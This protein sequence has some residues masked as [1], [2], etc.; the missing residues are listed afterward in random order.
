ML[1]NPN[2]TCVQLNNEFHLLPCGQALAYP[3]NSLKLNATAVAIW[4]YLSKPMSEDALVTQLACDYEIVTADLAEFSKEIHTFLEQLFSMQAI[5][6]EVTQTPSGVAADCH[7]SFLSNQETFLSEQDVSS[8][9]DFA[10]SSTPENVDA[11]IHAFTFCIAD[12]GLKLLTD[13]PADAVFPSEFTPFSSE[14]TRELAQ[15]IHIVAEKGPDDS[16]YATLISH[17]LL[18]VYE[19]SNGYLLRYPESSSMRSVWMS[20]DGSEVIIYV[21]P[22]YDA[23]LRSDIFHAIRVTFLYLAEKH[24]LYAI[25]S[26]SIEYRGKAWLFSGPSG[27]GKS[28]HT[29][30]WHDALSVERLNGDIN[31]IG[32]GEA[33]VPTVY[34][35]PWCGTS[36]IFTTNR[37][38]LGG[39][40]LL[41]QASNNQVLALSSSEQILGIVKRCIS[42]L[43]TRSQ[44]Q[45]CVALMEELLPS[46][47]VFHLHCTISQE[48]VNVIKDAIDSTF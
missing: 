24:D 44:M 5:T 41:S 43:W 16:A 22:P 25:H 29:N 27:T 15:T 9:T 48:A 4:N 23:T 12:L 46:I 7:A 39:I 18:C 10:C 40:T 20:R 3:H 38:P 13:L 21:K 31:L 35:I 6:E 32:K 2:F 36:E 34:G 17:P 1:Q 14:D 19:A 45:K 30:L 42:P 47:S 8:M 33:G 37:H 11:T 28:T 26:A